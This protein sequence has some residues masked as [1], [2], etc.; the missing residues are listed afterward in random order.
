MLMM[1]S[2]LR[3]KNI[4]LNCHRR[5]MTDR[6]KKG[7]A[8]K[9]KLIETEAPNLLFPD[10]CMAQHKGTPE[11]TAFSKPNPVHQHM[12]RK[13]PQEMLQKPHVT[14]RFLH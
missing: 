7:Q 2:G 8:N 3:Q 1:F 11:N 13:L 10:W 9:E 14:P 5:K 4:S 12:Y 6:A